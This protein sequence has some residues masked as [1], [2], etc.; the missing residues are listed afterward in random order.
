MVKNY[1]CCPRESIP[2]LRRES[3]DATPLDHRDFIAYK[4]IFNNYII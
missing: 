3:P 2:G 1:V 4:G